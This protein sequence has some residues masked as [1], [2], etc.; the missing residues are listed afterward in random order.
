MSRPLINNVCNTCCRRFRLGLAC[1]SNDFFYAPI[2]PLPVG[3]WAFS[4]SSLIEG[5][6]KTSD[7]CTA[8]HVSVYELI[9]FCRY[10]IV[11]ISYHEE[12]RWWLFWWYLPRSWSKWRKGCS[13][14]WKAWG[15][16]PA[17]S[18]RIQSISRASECPRICEG[19]LLWYAG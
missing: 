13:K 11:E 17:A 5:C 16:M 6:M 8:L 4:W 14:V 10:C 9:Y 7:V 15:S 19:T 12:G 2:S 3:Q 18:S 1:T